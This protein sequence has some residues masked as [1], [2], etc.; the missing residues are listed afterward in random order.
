MAKNTV[1]HFKRSNFE[2]D[3]TQSGHSGGPLLVAVP[4]ST[5]VVLVDAILVVPDVVADLL[6]AIRPQQ[7]DTL[8]KYILERDRR[9]Q[10][11]RQHKWF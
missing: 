11:R 1:P 5:L 8:L 10:Q 4:G 7:L 2:Y 3:S 6:V 9:R